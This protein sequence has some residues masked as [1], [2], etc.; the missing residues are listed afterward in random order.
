MKLFITG[1]SGFI[2]KELISECEKQKIEYTAVDIIDSNM[3]NHHKADIRSKDIVNLIPEGADAIIHLASLSSD[4]LCKDKAYDCFDLNVLATLNLIDAAHKKKV[5]QFIFASTEWVYGPFEEGEVKDENSLIDITKLDSEYALSKLVT[6]SNLRQKFQHGF[7]QVTILRFGI[8]YGSRKNG[9]A[10]E[11]IFD[12]IKTKDK[13]TV[14]SLKTGR[15]FIHVS[16]V[17]SGII[18]S[19]GLKGFNI[20]NL[21]G[22]KLIT[23]GDL[24]EVSKKILN[25]EIKIEESNPNNISVRTISNKK[26]KDILNWRPEISLQKGLTKLNFYLSEEDIKNEQ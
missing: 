17:V 23:L 25:K 22:D 16:D 3:P 24:I 8:I 20:I 9:S 7:C 19:I 21:Q 6:E 2:G 10:V 18:K 13:I 11:S 14:G 15:C 1:A 4:P 5:K 26:A 12:T